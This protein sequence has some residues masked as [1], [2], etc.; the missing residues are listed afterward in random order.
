MQSETADGWHD[1]WRRG[2]VYLHSGSGQADFVEANYTYYLYLMGSSCRATYMPRFCGVIWG[3]DGDLRMWGSMYWWHNQ[4]CL[5][6]GFTQSLELGH[7]GVRQS[8]FATFVD[9]RIKD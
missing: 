2:F 8:Q 4:G 7:L 6:D 3:T 5:F 9:Y 1:F